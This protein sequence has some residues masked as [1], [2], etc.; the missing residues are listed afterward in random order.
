MTDQE[1]AEKL[2]EI[3][4][5]NVAVSYWKQGLISTNQ[6]IVNLVEQN[7]SLLEKFLKVDAIAPRKIIVSDALTVYWRCP[8]ALIPTTD[9]RP[10]HQI[11]PQAEREPHANL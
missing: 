6:L 11:E 9:M 5:Q 2:D 1:A 7:K 4:T 3:A 8:M 10:G